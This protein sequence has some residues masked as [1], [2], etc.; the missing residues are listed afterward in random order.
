M[1]IREVMCQEVAGPNCRAALWLWVLW[2]LLLWVIH[3][4]C[5]STPSPAMFSLVSTGEHDL[6][7]DG[8][9]LWHWHGI[10]A[11]G[12]VCGSWVLCCKIHCGHWVSCRT[13]GQLAGLPLPNAEGHLC[14]GWW[15]APFQVR[16]ML[17][18]INSIMSCLYRENVTHCQPACHFDV[19]A[20]HI[21][22]GT[23]HIL[24]KS[25]S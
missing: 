13:D 3:P 4:C 21:D 2:L 17:C 5:Q 15:W 24:A 10:P 9:I 18:R 1:L 11:Y 6:N 19:S 22:C 14:H 20:C 8:A 16:F 7:S 25:L 12:D 23:C